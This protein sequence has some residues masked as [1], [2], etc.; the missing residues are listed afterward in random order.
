MI[1]VNI[2]VVLRFQGE[3]SWE[4]K[5]DSE[6]KTSLKLGKLCHAHHTPNFVNVVYLKLTVKGAVTGQQLSHEFV[7]S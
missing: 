1:L 6:L 7:R 3:D 4:Y 5:F 2:V